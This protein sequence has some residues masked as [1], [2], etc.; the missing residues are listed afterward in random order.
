MRK[1][2]NEP[3]DSVSDIQLENISE[4]KRQAEGCLR[5]Y[6]TLNI[7]TRKRHYTASISQRPWS[8]F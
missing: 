1:S 3:A 2:S 7:P 4:T 6:W 5:N 8:N